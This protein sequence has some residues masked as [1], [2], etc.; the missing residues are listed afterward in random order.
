MQEWFAKQSRLARVR[1]G[2]SRIC[3]PKPEL[4]TEIQKGTR[5]DR[6]CS[7]GLQAV[8]WKKSDPSEVTAVM[9]TVDPVHATLYF[10]GPEHAGNEFPQEEVD[11][12]GVTK[13]RLHSL[14]QMG[15]AYWGENLMGARLY[16]FDNRNVAKH[17]YFPVGPELFIHYH[18]ERGFMFFHVSL[19]CSSKDRPIYTYGL[20]KASEST[21]PVE[22]D[23]QS[24][25]YFP[26][27]AFV[28]L[29]TSQLIVD[30]FVDSYGDDFY[31]GVDW[32]QCDLD[33]SEPDNWR[34]LGEMQ[35]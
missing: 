5:L 20:K 9:I 11:I 18:H 24:A 32:V 26:S 1:S 3:G 28:D 4:G 6:D 30:T 13:E 12:R 21:E 15:E 35:N 25:F 22:M 27:N 2:A 8:P 17:G 10:Q 7:V 14:L 33:F 16:W 31:D 34:K 29:N 23:A 19:R